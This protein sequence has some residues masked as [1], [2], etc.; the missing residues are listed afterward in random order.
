[1]HVIKITESFGQI[2]HYYM[3]EISQIRIPFSPK[4]IVGGHHQE[5]QK[6]HSAFNV[7]AKG[8]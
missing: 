2:L 7:K 3:P 4:L 8:N 5:E 6:Y 1:M